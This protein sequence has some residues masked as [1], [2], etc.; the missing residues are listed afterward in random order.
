[1]KKYI[2]ISIILLQSI[3]IFAQKIRVLN[4]ENSQPVPF[5]AV[6]FPDLKT[7]A[8]TDENGFFSTENLPKTVLGQ[9]SCVGYKTWL[10]QIDIQKV[11]EVFLTPDAHDLQ[12]IV[13]AGYSSKL[14]GENVLNVE[15]LT[16]SAENQGV[17]LVE[18][19]TKI[20]GLD[21]FSTGASIGKPVIRGLSG[22]RIAVFAQGV[23]LENQ[24]WGDE[25]G[26]GLDE[27]GFENVEV[28][29]GA[30]SLLYGSDAIGGV[31]C[32]VD[33]RFANENSVEA[34]LSAE[35]QANTNG[36]RNNAAIKFSKNRWRANFFG[37]Y[38]QH[39][40]YKDGNRNSV[41]NS[42]FRNGDFKTAIGYSGKNFVTSLKYSFLAEKYG[43][44][45]DPT[46]TLPEGE[47]V[48]D[49]SNLHKICSVR[50]SP[51]FGGGRGEVLPFQTINT[52][53]IST[54]NSIFLQNNSKLQ[55]DLGA[56]LNRRKEF[57][58][59]TPN[60]SPS[61]EG[62]E[63]EL[64]MNLSTISYNFRWYS[65]KFK[66]KISLIVGSQGMF[67]NNQNFGNEELIPNANTV[68]FGLFAV[69]DFYYSKKSFVQFGLRFDNRNISAFEQQSPENET[70]VGQA[71]NGNGLKKNYSSINFSAGIFQPI[72]KNL[73]MRLNFSSGFRAPT[74]F[75]LLSDGIHEGTNRY[76]KG[77]S[78]LKTENS[79]QAD[80]S[81]NF[82]SKHLEFFIN[83][84]VN[85]FKN[86]I[87][88]Q[89]TDSIVDNAQVFD[90]VQNSAILYGGEAAFHFHPHP[91]DWLHFDGSYSATFGENVGAERALPLPLMPSQ[92]IKLTLQG[93]FKFKKILTNFSVFLNYQYSFAQNRIAVYEVQT[94]DYHLFNCGMDF[95][96]L[97]GKQKLFLNI[98]ANNIF[99]QK[100]FDHL[101][102]YKT[103][104][105][106]NIG[107]NFIV[108][109]TVPF[110]WKI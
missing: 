29:K 12:E 76:E 63:A 57:A 61:G 90:Y 43:L 36:F 73:S 45:P 86:Y 53:I 31:L 103:E 25:H 15:K 48:A 19:L 97:F 106:L 93:N 79:Y 107:R 49:I 89:P 81:L 102:R 50:R 75:E 17:N 51:S 84:Y 10:Q 16:L 22:N 77:N 58:D 32:F 96:F 74:M 27:N 3:N 4:L 70:V 42:R 100:Y 72:Y 68:D 69:S 82:N 39:F 71:R 18:K 38:T 55:L 44:L 30:A 94:P 2:I 26:L 40:D 108:K 62:N 78:E 109:I 98:S 24:Q 110:E 11:T 9:I 65:P 91:V 54:E 104:G 99:N 56:V 21:N 5:A 13:V 41:I 60:T 46:P 6:Y 35:Y 47:G 85:F 83:P 8:N 23:R 14:Q 67:Q 33:E 101:S 1:M 28:I 66:D 7:G 52:H 105:I 64:D 34:R 88:L 37:G 92:K 95:D 59:L 80:F 87:Y 20:A